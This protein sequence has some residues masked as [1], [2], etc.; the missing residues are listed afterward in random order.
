[1]RPSLEQIKQQL[2][3]SLTPSTLVVIDESAHHQGHP[4]MQP[5]NYHLKISIAAPCL[6]DLSPIDAHR[7]IYATLMHWMDQYI[8]A[9]SIEVLT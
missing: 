1:M 4:G 3:V 2:T 9:I 6:N 7:K 8:H 5:G